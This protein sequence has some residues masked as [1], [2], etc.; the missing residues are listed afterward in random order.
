VNE[1]ARYTTPDGKFTLLLV[2]G[3]D[4]IGFEEY[5]WHTHGDFLPSVYQLGSVPQ[6][7]EALFSDRLVMAVSRT[8]DSVRD[9]CVTDDPESAKESVLEGET[10]ELR[11]WSGRPYHA[12]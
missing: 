7:L 3:D 9:V 2:P 11:Y 4:L 5:P 1:T 6:F 8:G 12:G 10:L